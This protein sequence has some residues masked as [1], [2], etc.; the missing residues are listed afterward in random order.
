MLTGSCSAYTGGGTTASGLPAAVGNVAVNPNVIPYGTRLYI[1]SPDGSFVYGYA[2]AAD[3]G[4]AFL[5]GDYLADLYYDTLSDCYSFGIRTM[6]VY[7]LD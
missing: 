6:N 5:Y 3:T 1:C 4:G 7:I 2:V